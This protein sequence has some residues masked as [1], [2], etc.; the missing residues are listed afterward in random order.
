M[1]VLV[2]PPDELAYSG[3]GGA[4]PIDAEIL[5]SVPFLLGNDPT[6]LAL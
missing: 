4:L 2:S 3:L 5:Y 6:T 1:A